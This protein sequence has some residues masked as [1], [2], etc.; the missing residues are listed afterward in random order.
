[1]F[2]ISIEHSE[3]KSYCAKERVEVIFMNNGITM[4]VKTTA[5][6][7]NKMKINSNEKSSEKQ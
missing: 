4:N 1:M 3:E 5:K 7:V 6:S 2:R